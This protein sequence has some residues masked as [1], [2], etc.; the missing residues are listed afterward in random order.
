MSDKIKAAVLTRTKKLEVREFIKPKL[1]PDDILLKVILCGICGSDIHF[2]KGKLGISEALILGHEFIGEVAEG[3][4]KALEERGLS[5]GDL[6]AVE[7]VMP[8]YHCNWC[9]EGKYRLCGNDDTSTG[10]FGRQFGCNIP[11]T[12]EPTPLWGGFSQY[13]FVPREAIIHKYKKGVDVKSAVMTEPFATAIHTIERVAPLIGESCAILGPGTIGLCLT[14]AAK[15]KGLYPII[16]IGSGEK[17]N[18]RLELGKR[19]GADYVINLSNEKKD[20]I[21]LIREVAKDTG[22]DISIDASGASPAQILGI[23]I[24]KRGG[25]TVLVGISNKQPI[26][27]IPDTDL[28]F[29]ETT[30]FGSILN[31]GYGKAVKLIE[32]KQVHVGRLVTHEFALDDIREAFKFVKERKDNVIKAVINPWKSE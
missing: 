23:K 32:D 10:G 12:R 15:L 7:I 21:T 6:V 8:C 19:L 22:V 20:P 16:L 1:G 29:K 17:D 13:L 2:W 11:I 26:N 24:L 18:Y 28:V 3:G 30:I 4:D 9:K 25:R 14:I 31:K 27:I 5:I